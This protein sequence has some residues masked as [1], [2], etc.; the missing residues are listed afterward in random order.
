MRYPSSESDNGSVIQYGYRDRNFAKKKKKKKKQIPK[1]YIF[2][3][4]SGEQLV[5]LFSG[6]VKKI[7]IFEKVVLVWK[8]VFTCFLWKNPNFKNVFFFFFF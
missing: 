7:F 3:S 4:V 1:Y 8:N 5:C 2:S 6:L